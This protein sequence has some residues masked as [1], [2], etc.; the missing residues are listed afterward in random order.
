VKLFHIERAIHD[1]L[2][3]LVFEK[4]FERF[5]NLRIAS[6]ENGSEFLPD[7]FK[8][9]GEKY[10]YGQLRVIRAAQPDNGFRLQERRFGS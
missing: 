4:L 3:T 2:S 6:V 9:L 10:S 7:L 1:F 8:K 5:P